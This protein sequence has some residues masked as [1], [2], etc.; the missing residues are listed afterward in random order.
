MLGRDTKG[1]HGTCVL[2][3]TA[4]P[5]AFL[6]PQHCAITIT[7]DSWEQWE[8]PQEPQILYQLPLVA[9]DQRA[10]GYQEIQQDSLQLQRGPAS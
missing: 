4:T 2:W 8:T 9:K 10:A 5:H 1:P 6:Q 7:Q 3:D